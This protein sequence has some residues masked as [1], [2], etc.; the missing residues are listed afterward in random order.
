MDIPK[1]DNARGQ[2]GEVGTAVIN[3]S[4]RTPPVTT[5]QCAQVLNLIRQH[6]PI[7]SLRLTADCAIPEAAA[8][9]HDLR[10]AGWNIRTEIRPVVIFRGVE[11]RNIA[12][13]SL[14][15]PEWPAPGFH[16]PFKEEPD[17][18]ELDLHVD[19]EES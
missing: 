2:A 6:Q 14:G 11:R 3:A 17:Q 13:Y 9:V 16:Q 8:R 10:A 7:I 19:V 5:G 1:N 15:T 4:D 18:A 12:S